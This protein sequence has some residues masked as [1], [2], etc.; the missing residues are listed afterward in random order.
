[1]KQ[2]REFDLKCKVKV[3]H[4]AY[5]EVADG[6]QHETTSVCL[7][8][9]MEATETWMFLTAWLPQAG[10]ICMACENID[11]NIGSD[12]CPKCG[13]SKVKTEHNE[14]PAFVTYPV[15]SP[16]RM[17]VLRK[18]K[19]CTEHHLFVMSSG[20]EEELRHMDGKQVNVR[21][22]P[23]SMDYI[24]DAAPSVTRTVSNHP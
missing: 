14:C 2:D 19:Y 18:N 21:V 12:T 24:C 17:A 13:S 7:V 15:N 3:I 23:A 1:M 6:R 5:K 22:F 11:L 9:D 8:P 20:V 4:Q 10:T 16:C